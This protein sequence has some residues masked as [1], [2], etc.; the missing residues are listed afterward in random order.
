MS[1]TSFYFFVFLLAL[2]VVYY[3]LPLK[4][5]WVALL[6]ASIGFYISLGIKFLPFLLAAG[7]LS[8][9]VSFFLDKDR[10]AEKNVSQKVRKTVIIIAV[11]IQV[12]FLVYTKIARL[13]TADLP[14]IVPVGLS[15]YT[16]STVG[17][18]LDIYWKHYNAEKNPLK[19]L[20]F[21]SFFPHIMLGPI[22]R[23]DHL[24]P[25]L[26]E[27]HRFNYEQ[28]CFGV[29]LMIW[30]LFEKLVLSDRI[31]VFVDAVIDE[32]YDTYPGWLLAMAVF[33]YA[34]QIYTDFAGC[35]N[36]ARGAAELYGIE[37]EQNF[38]QP[39]FATS[40]EDYWRRWHIT[41]GAWFRDYLCMPI[42]MS[43]PVKQMSKAARKKW[44]A[45]AG[46]TTMTA[47]PLIFVWIAT[48]LWHGT[49]WNYVI[50]GVFQGG[51][52]IISVILTPAF[53][54]WKQ[55]L[56]IKDENPAWRL[57]Q[58]LRT[59]LLAA[60]I[61]RIITRAP[62]LSAAWTIMK[63]IVTD[64]Q[65][66]GMAGVHAVQFGALGMDKM[67]FIISVF[68]MLL[69]LY[70]GIL[71]ETGHSVRKMVAGY[72]I[73]VRWAIYLFVFLFIL[74]FGMYGPSFDV[75]SFQYVDF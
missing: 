65:W 34:V 64:F 17:Y 52:I 66:T 50:W 4:F 7:V 57:F 22:A 68:G 32:G 18:M 9:A 1:Y 29:Q 43:K 8:W 53:L 61:P 49:G 39:Y 58:M 40:V 46:R 59:F 38:N 26:A 45:Q 28:I 75:S 71:R 62:S 63:R 37:L 74:L 36:I 19:V 67:N 3:I 30:G 10:C 2:A 16:F 14:L 24:G 31:G 41:L 69:L 21:V 48:G 33:F 42:A 27:G 60:I 13:I 5:R 23:Y 70:V 11:I 6:C 73:P 51:I 25:Q 47:F 12:G 72:V 54:K 15:Y 56:H 35:V 44:G 20:L 55:A